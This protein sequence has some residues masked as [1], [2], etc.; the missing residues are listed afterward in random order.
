MSDNGLEVFDRTLHTTHVW[1]D[2]VMQDTDA[3]RQT[4][5]HL[6]GTVLRNLRDCLPTSLTAHL[7]AQ[8]PLLLRGAFFERWQPSE[9]PERT[10]HQET[11]LQRVDEEMA[12]TKQDI[13][14]ATA[15]R[16]VFATLARH[17]DSGQ[18]EK[19]KGSLHKELVALW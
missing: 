7:G 16:A 19:V 12:K 17:I 10:R 15:T 6:L 18:V 8:L 4:A 3:S 1:L 5:W 13:D 2:D 11:F 9:Q 14:P